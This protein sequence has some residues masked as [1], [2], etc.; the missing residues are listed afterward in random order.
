MT[1]VEQDAFLQRVLFCFLFFHQG[2]GQLSRPILQQLHVVQQQVVERQET[3][4]VPAEVPIT[5]SQ[6]VSVGCNVLCMSVEEVEG[7]ES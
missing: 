5:I 4:A 7:Q 1:T 2:G 3:P 6:Q